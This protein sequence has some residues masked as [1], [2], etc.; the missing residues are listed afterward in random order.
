MALNRAWYNALVDDNGTNTVGT[1]WNKTQILG[2]YDTIDAELARI[3]ATSTFGTFQPYIT[4]DGTGGTPVYSEQKGAWSKVGRQMFVGGRV[5]MTSKGSLAGTGPVLLAN[6]PT[7]SVS[8]THQSGIVI[9]FFAGLAVTKSWLT[10]YMNPGV[11][12]AYLTANAPGGSLSNAVLDS[13]EITGNF[14]LMFGGS[15]RID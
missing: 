1:V 3:D 4:I 13:S 15:Y 2:L 14:Y 12:F 10:T 6:L 7:P 8:T 11:N 9:G 5:I